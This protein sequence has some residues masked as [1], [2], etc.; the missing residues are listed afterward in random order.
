MDIILILKYLVLGLIQGLTEPI[1][2][3]SSGHLQIIQHFFNIKTTSLTFEILVN[4]ASLLAVLIIY[5]QDIYRLIA[6]G[7]GYFKT[8]SPENTRDFKFI[9]YLIVGTIPAGVIGVLFGDD[10]EA[11]VSDRIITVGITL[12][13]TGIALWLIRNLRGR[14]NDG[15][16]NVKDAIIV[17]LAQAV[18]L[19]PGISRSGA[20][21][22]AAMG[23]GMKP[24]T[25][26]RFSFLLYIPVSF[27]VMLL[28]IKDLINDPNLGELAVPYIVAFLASLIASYYALRWFMGIMARGNL[29][30]FAI[31]CFVVGGGV[32]LF[33]LL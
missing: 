5:R 19:I 31:Y 1:P 6:N 16:L 33:S 3:S 25:A 15:D 8:K 9:L 22:V 7:L 13:I 32:T 12:I 29:K 23:R 11:L 2:I 24:E 21:I 27:G 10:I 28:G 30:V 20:T 18:A 26:L 17:G 14:K 4:T